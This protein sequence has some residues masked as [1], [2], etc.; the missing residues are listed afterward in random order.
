[1]GLA[2]ALDVPVW[3]FFTGYEQGGDC[4]VV[5]AGQGVLVG[6]LANARLEAAQTEESVAEE[7]RAKAP[8]T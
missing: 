5:S 2:G 3:R 6:R 7:P 1:M 4:A 8:I